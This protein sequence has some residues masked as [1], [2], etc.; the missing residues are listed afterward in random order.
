MRGQLA[1]PVPRGAR[2]S[3]GPRLLDIHRRPRLPC[4]ARRVARPVLVRLHASF[5]REKEREKSVVPLDTSGHISTGI[6]LFFEYREDAQ[7]VLEVLLKR[8][9]KLGLTLHPQKTRLIEFGG[10]AYWKARRMAIKPDTFDLLGFTH[11]ATRTR[12]GKFTVH[13]KTMRK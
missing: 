9:A 10:Q 3:N 2:A 8:S 5:N 7:K 1:S 13:V 4:P 6:G 11:L 12:P